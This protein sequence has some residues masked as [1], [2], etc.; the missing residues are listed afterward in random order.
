MT[1]KK[2]NVNI[3]VYASSAWRASMETERILKGEAVKNFQV[4]RPVKLREP[5]ILIQNLV[6]D[7]IFKALFFTTGEYHIR[8]GT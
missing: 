3:V 7:F 6:Q 1:Q 2:V 4:L 8:D 5:H